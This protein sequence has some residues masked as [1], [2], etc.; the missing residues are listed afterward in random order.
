MAER[1]KTGLRKAMD[2]FCGERFPDEEIVVFGEAH[3][4][5]LDEGFMGVGQRINQ[6]PVAIYDRERCIE[7]L[8]QEFR[9]IPV[10]D[11]DPYDEAEEYF[12]FNTEGSWVGERTPIVIS[13]FSLPGAAGATDRTDNSGE[14]PESFSFCSGTGG[15]ATDKT[16][17]TDGTDDNEC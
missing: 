11:K 2:E 12:S 4:D 17:K 5:S 13:R 15:N 8:A 7:A 10:G 16:D 6:V 3:G 9:D 1:S 14:L